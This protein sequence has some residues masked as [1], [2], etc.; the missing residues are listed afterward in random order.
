MTSRPGYRDR[1]EAGTRVKLRNAPTQASNTCRL[2]VT[3][4]SPRAPFGKLHRNLGWRALRI[5][6]FLGREQGAWF[7]R[8]L[9]ANAG[10]TRIVE[11][12]FNA[13]HS[14]C[15]FLGARDDITVVSFDLGAHGYVARAK[16]YVDATF[17]GRHT[18]VVGD[19]RETLP[20]YRADHPAAAFDLAFVDGGHDYDVARA[21]LANI[22]PLIRPSGLI[23]MDDLTPWRTY[24][25]G[26]YRAWSEAKQ[27]GL[28]SELELLQDG[29]TVPAIQRRAQT[30]AWGVGRPAAHSGQRPRSPS[31]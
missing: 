30:T 4:A 27:R 7:A 2:L 14:S 29:R 31:R 21:D 26:P 9:A 18:L 24:G 13:G 6:G 19:S 10:I 11:V 25:A 23:V 28:I 5:E 16:Q 12:G 17:P 1:K 3:A 22:L 20:A 15:V 8:L